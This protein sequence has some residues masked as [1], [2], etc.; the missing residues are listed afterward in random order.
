[1]KQS[2]VLSSELNDVVCQL[3]V[4]FIVTLLSHRI[5]DDLLMSVRVSVLA[6]FTHFDR[7]VTQKAFTTTL[8]GSFFS[9]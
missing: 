8:T 9:V 4:F 2:K 7:N 3:V 6:Y 1:M 5:K